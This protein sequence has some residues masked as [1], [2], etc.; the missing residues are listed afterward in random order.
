MKKIIAIAIASLS[1]S[2]MADNKHMVTLS[3]YET[4]DAQDRSLDFANSTGTVIN[5]SGANQNQSTRRLALNYAYAVT[6]D[7]QVG[8]NYKMNDVKTSGDVAE[9]G[10][11]ST[12]MGV[13]VIYNFAH[14]LT[15]TNYLALHYDVSKL[16]ESEAG[17]DETK[18]NTWGLEF[19]HRFSIGNIWGMNFNYSPSATVSVAKTTT[20]LN[21]NDD[22]S[23]TNVSVN[24]VK[25][26]VLF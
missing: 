16:D 2:A 22:S 6:S 25:F 21:D 12:S 15:D 9:L 18:T 20:D 11:K 1:L 7:F 3:G 8:V 4:G 14:Q 24:F 19:G 13:Q 10:D 23:T 26:D 5:D 17:D